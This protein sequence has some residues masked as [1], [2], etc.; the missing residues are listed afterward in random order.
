MNIDNIMEHVDADVWEEHEEILSNISSVTIVV[1]I[2]LTIII[3]II[4]IKKRKK[5]LKYLE[6]FC[7]SYSF[8]WILLSVLFRHPWTPYLISVMKYAFIYS[9]ILTFVIYIINKVRNR[10]SRNKESDKKE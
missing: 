7:I 2:L 6:V 10:R 3:G 4:L 8:I 9:I 5:C 1:S